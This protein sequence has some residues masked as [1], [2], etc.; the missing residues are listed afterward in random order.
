LPQLDVTPSGDAEPEPAPGLLAALDAASIG[1]ALV[2]PDGRF[3]RVN[4]ALA[5]LVGRDRLA[6]LESSLAELAY[7]E[8]AHRD[9]LA[10]EQFL[11]GRAEPHVAEM[12]FEHAAGGFVWVRRGLTPIHDDAGR[13]VH[14]AL[15]VVDVSERVL[16]EA[17]LHQSE[18]WYRAL[19]QHTSDLV[20]VIGFDDG[21][22][23]ASPSAEHLLGFRPEDLTGLRGRD[24]IHPDDYAHATA[25]FIGQ[26]D[27][28]RPSE[29][30]ELRGRR[31]DGTW[32]WFEARAN[33]LPPEI[34]TDWLVVNARDI[35]ERKRHESQQADLEARFE[36]AFTQ[37]P[38]GIVFT[39]LDG[40]IVWANASLS[41]L[42]GVVPKE[43]LHARQRVLWP[44]EDMREEEAL[45]RAL[46]R[47]DI[48]S[49]QF[50]QRF[51]HPDG[52]LRWGLVHVSLVRDTQGAPHWVL[53]QLEDITDR[54]HREL[55]LAHDA[56]HEPLTGLWNRNGFCRLL[57]QAWSERAGDGTLAVL[58]V[59]LDG[60][61]RVNDDH[62]H[63]VGDEILVH[64]AQRLR[65]AVRAGDVVARWGGDEFVVLCPD[66]DGAVEA[67]EV[68]AR[69][70]TMVAEPFRV[71]GGAVRIGA[72]IGVAVDEGHVD[73]RALVRDADSASYLAK[74]QGRGRVEHAPPPGP[75]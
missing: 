27:G 29:T 45:G 37:S 75:S 14:L 62:G 33:R 74:R 50:E 28:T 13:L 72:S 34:A 30:V 2:R 43:L 63:V 58:F 71:V 69:L 54:K 60:F 9:R 3:V 41:T 65:Q 31:A 59:D 61:K 6:L 53:G 56:E 51:D 40:T 70:C 18:I 24:V 25:A 32:G 26:L 67:E 16:A 68:A 47:G 4:R 66:I 11:A 73:P 5:R 22:H 55:A 10:L 17:T 64:V 46:L 19:V 39:D 38:I 8:D 42:V 7:P 12:R 36:A 44:S 35:T 21:I 23:Y 52:R 1:V 20:L 57:D 49:F 48:D 15:Q